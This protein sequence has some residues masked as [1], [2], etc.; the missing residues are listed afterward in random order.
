V[1]DLARLS[2]VPTPNS[3][4]SPPAT[5]EQPHLTSTPPETIIL[6]YNLKHEDNRRIPYPR[7]KD[8]VQARA[9]WTEE[10]RSRVLNG[11][12]P[13][14]MPEFQTVVSFSSHLT[15]TNFSQVNSLYNTSGVRRKNTYVT[16]PQN[17]IEG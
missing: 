12:H 5:P 13:K 16:L 14:D 2:P 11:A 15:K 6:D 1:L 8:R 3:L 7:G 10:E 17:V 9:E 4:P